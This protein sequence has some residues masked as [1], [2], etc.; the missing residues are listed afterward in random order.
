MPITRTKKA[1]LRKYSPLPPSPLWDPWGGRG[2]GVG[3]YTSLNRPDEV[4]IM[5]IKAPYP[6]SPSP[7]RVPMIA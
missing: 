3:D 2:R 1:Y 4:L 5:G 6:P 7:L